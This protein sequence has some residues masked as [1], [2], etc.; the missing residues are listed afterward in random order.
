MNIQMISGQMLVLFSMMFIGYL[1]WKK[2]CFDDD[3][4]EKLSAVIL[5][6]F[7]PLLIINGVLGKK[8]VGNHSLVVENLIL[9]IFFFVFLILFGF[10]IVKIV[11]PETEHK[12]MYKVMTVIPNV[13]FMGIPVITSIYGKESMIYII[14]YILISNVLLY[15]YGSIMIGNPVGERRQKW[16]WR[17][18][19]GKICN[20]GVIA[21]II[22]IVIFFAQIYIPLP[23]STLCNYMGNTT[24]PLSMLLIGMSIAKADLKRIFT[25][26]KIYLFITIRMLIT[27]IVLIFIL[28]NLPLDPTVLGVF[29]LQMAM[30]VGSIPIFIAKEKG[31][32]ATC[33][34]EAVVLSTLCSFV[35][36]PVSYMIL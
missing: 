21:G 4:Y 33:C 34:I 5:K 2:R 25:N 13:G 11:H 29:A 9:S 26:P 23:V 7:N 17:R 1:L 14:S 8:S 30:P 12:N 28:K 16:M 27:P 3:S 10:V 18:G 6:V 19:L 31:V 36:I 15:T 20:T 24:I 32:D 35:T 22:A